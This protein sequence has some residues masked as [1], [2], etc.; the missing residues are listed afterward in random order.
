AYFVGVIA[1]G[2]GDNGQA[3]LLWTLAIAIANGIVFLSAPVIGAI[4]D[5]SA[6]KKRFLLISTLGCVVFTALLALCGPGE[7]VLAMILII[8]SS[9]MFFTSENLI[10]AFLP[11]ICP[12]EKM[13]RISAYGWTLGYLGG[14]LT[15]G[16]CLYIVT[17]AKAAGLSAEVYVPQTML[18]VA[19]IFFLASLPTFLWLKER[20]H[21]QHKGEL[22]YLQI[23]YQRL[24]L[25]LTHLPLYRDMFTFLITLTVY[26]C[27]VYTVIVLASVYA[28]EVMGF[29]TEDSIKL[30]LVVNITAA[31]GAFCFGWLQ[32]RWGSKPT[33]MFT[34]FIWLCAAVLAHYTEQRFWFWVVANLVGVAMGASQ[35]AGRALVGQFSPPE[36]S[37]EFFGLWGLAT[38]LSAIIGPMVYGLTTYLTQ[39]DHRS[40]ILST[41]VFFLLGI[42]LLMFVN[43]ERGRRAAHVDLN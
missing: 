6:L 28:Q 39:G 36:R 42:I 20:A 40:A 11:E 21:A 34:L 41:A 25:T 13:G 8:L 16:V 30:I 31:A 35:S 23:G 24:R 18:V 9:L 7:I 3:T 27:G 19:A 4:A 1:N 12:P 43:V 17:S 37:G 14:M 29:T 5:H 22:N 2:S 38:K 15:L 26:Q 33:L 10:S 32:D